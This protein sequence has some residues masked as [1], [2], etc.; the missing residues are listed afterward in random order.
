MSLPAI[1]VSPPD[2]TVAPTRLTSPRWS[3]AIPPSS[4]F[5]AFSNTSPPATIVLPCTVSCW[6]SFIV[7][8][9]LKVLFLV[10]FDLQNV[11]VD[12]FNHYIVGFMTGCF[13]L[14]LALVKKSIE[15]DPLGYGSKIR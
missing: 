3:M 4:V 14:L 10:F 1:T 6:D 8:F 5:C 9:F 13:L 11:M 7:T 2:C 15:A 12:Y